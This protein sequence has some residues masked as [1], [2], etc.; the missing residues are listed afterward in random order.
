MNITTTAGETFTGDES[1]MLARLLFKRW[2]RDPAAFCSAW[3]RLFEN[4]A[5]DAEILKLLNERPTTDS[6]PFMPPRLVEGVIRGAELHGEESE[7]DMEIGD[8][9]G[10][11]RAAY[12]LLSPSKREAFLATEEV[13]SILEWLEG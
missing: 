1:R 11:L 2:G 12:K 13:K 5:P 9:Q 6:V 7:P 10:A 3:R 8:L 4:N